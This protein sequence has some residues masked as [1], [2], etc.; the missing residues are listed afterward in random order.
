MISGNNDKNKQ[1]N[2]KKNKQTNPKLKPVVLP[3]A[4]DSSVALASVMLGKWGLIRSSIVTVAREL[5]ADE[6][7]LGQKHD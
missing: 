7:V 6:M 1:T 2:E 4:L 5:K 3:S